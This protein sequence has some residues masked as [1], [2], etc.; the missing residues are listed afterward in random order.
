MKKP[1][2]IYIPNPLRLSKEEEFRVGANYLANSEPQW[3][4]LG[5]TPLSP[6]EL[7]KKEDDIKKAFEDQAKRNKKEKNMNRRQMLS[8]GTDKEQ[9]WA[10]SIP[11]IQYD[12]EQK[13]TVPDPNW[14]DPNAEV[15]E[16]DNLEIIESDPGPGV[17][18]EL[19]DIEEGKYFISVKG[20]IVASFDSMEKTQQMLEYIVLDDSAPVKA[21]MEEILVFQRLKIKTGIWVER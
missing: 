9:G 15:Q 13:L 18:L 12:N 1:F 17:D 21:E 5:F 20:V 4:K 11:P 6:L 2:E 14:V 3:E 16:E 19:S 10:S 7:K 8:V